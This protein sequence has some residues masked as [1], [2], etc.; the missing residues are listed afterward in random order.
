MFG[1]KTWS[2][3]V[4]GIGLAGSIGT[5]ALLIQKNSNLRN[6][7]RESQIVIETMEE[8]VALVD[9]LRVKNEELGRTLTQVLIELENADVEGLDNPIPPELRKLLERMR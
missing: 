6:E 4:I 3:F 1:V 8:Q 5:C 9:D 7:V 2:A